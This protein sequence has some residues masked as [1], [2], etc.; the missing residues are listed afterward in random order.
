MAD[1][2]PAATKQARRN[3]L[4]ELQKGIVARRQKA[5]VGEAVRV[6]VDG[7][8][9]DSELVLTGRLE[10]QAPDIDSIVYFDAVDPSMLKAG[11]IVDARVTGAR[12]YD[13]V[14]TV[15]DLGFRFRPGVHTGPAS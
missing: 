2:I 10:G 11:D 15:E 12:G 5:R 7:P 9:P 1:D 6:L 13:L 4:L 14:A 3:R 8:S